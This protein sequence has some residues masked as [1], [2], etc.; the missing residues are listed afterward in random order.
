MFAASSA[1][2]PDSSRSRPFPAAAVAAGS[3]GAP[4]RR[5]RRRAAPTRRRARTVLGA[6]DVELSARGA[7]SRAGGVWGAGEERGRTGKR[8]E[9]ARA[10]APRSAPY[11][12]EVD[13]REGARVEQR[14]ERHAGHRRCAG[15]QL[16]GRLGA[17]RPVGRVRRPF[18]SVLAPTAPRAP[19]P[20]RARRV[21][22]RHRVVLRAGLDREHLGPGSARDS[23]VGSRRS[24]PASTTSAQAPGSGA[25][26][27]RAAAVVAT[28]L[29]CTAASVAPRRDRA[30]RG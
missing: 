23:H 8:G 3:A 19:R 29:L 28:V 26:P 12:Q 30:A 11:L 9:T 17:E 20:R 1:P 18:I 27:P 4:R 6:L 24:V 13:A 15:P 25:A 10:R 2:S 22:H 14:V 21:E 5:A 7:R 16:R